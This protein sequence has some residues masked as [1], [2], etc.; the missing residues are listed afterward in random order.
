MNLLPFKMLLIWFIDTEVNEVKKRVELPLAEPLY[1]THNNQG[2]G[3]AIAVNNP[4]IRNWYLNEVMN[5]SCYRKFLSGY[6]SPIISIVNGSWVANPYF[7][8]NKVSSEFAKGYINPIIREM[9]DNGVY[10]AFGG[11]DDYYVKGKSWYKERHF[12][13]DGLICGYDQE[14]KTYCICAYD[15][16]WVYR[17]FWTPQKCFNAG[18]LAMRKQ[19]KYCEIWGLR[20]KDDI[21]EFS[22]KI[23]YSNLKKYLDSNREKYPFIEDE[24]KVYGIVVHEFIA[25]YVS[26]LYN[27]DIPY[28]RMDRRVFRMIWEH[29]KV[30][31]ERIMLV[32]KTLEYDNSISE[33][34]K[35]IVSE[36]DT[37]RMLYASHHLKR[38]DSVLPI[39]KEKLLA[40]MENER[41]LLELLLEKMEK[42][43]ENESV[44]LS[45]K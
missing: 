6:T 37:M 25:E 27:G 32:E 23:V 15:S 33:R 11:V 16:S 5:L 34:Y 7:E 30:M 40:L 13:H 42:E 21:I 39:I 10:V 26:K 20:V 2:P 45:E 28:E 43:I 19:G 35:H 9:I 17:K 12:S 29:K 14:E 24:S 4:T 3:T 8:K 41:E 18:R 44:E 22:P 38:R 36:A 31:L 1:K